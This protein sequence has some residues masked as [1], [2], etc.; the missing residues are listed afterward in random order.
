MLR[1][2]SEEFLQQG[3]IM[4]GRSKKAVS[5]AEQQ[6]FRAMF[7]TSPEIC[8]L[9]WDHLDPPNSMPNEVKAFHLLWGLMFLKLYASEVVHCAIAGGVDEKTFRK[10]SWLFVS[11]IADLSP[12]VVSLNSQDHFLR[13]YAS[14]SWLLFPKIVW[15]NRFRNSIGNLCLVSVDGTDFRIYEKTPFWPG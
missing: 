9:L 4:L 8:S 6:R 2:S 1:V 15:A 3:R 14:F 13:N 5:A 10:W 11:A 12:N 7:G